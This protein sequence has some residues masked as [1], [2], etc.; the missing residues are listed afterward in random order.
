M[1]LLKGKNEDECD[2]E[3]EENCWRFRSFASPETSLGVGGGRSCNNRAGDAASSAHARLPFC[4]KLGFGAVDRHRPLHLQR[5]FNLTSVVAKSSLFIFREA[6]SHPS[7][8]FLIFDTVSP[9]FLPL[10]AD[11]QSVFVEHMKADE[12][13]PSAQGGTRVG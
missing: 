11:Q 2:P 4:T 13:R 5:M 3:S 12:S 7:I 1:K 9:R 6:Q 10:A 8:L